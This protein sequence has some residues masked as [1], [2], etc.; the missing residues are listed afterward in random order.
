[1]KEPEHDPFGRGVAARRLAAA[2]LAAGLDPFSDGALFSS[3]KI[4]L[5]APDAPGPGGETGGKRN[6]ELSR[7]GPPPWVHLVDSDIVALAGFPLWLGAQ[8]FRTRLHPSHGALVAA[9]PWLEPGCI[10][11]DLAGPMWSAVEVLVRL[12]GVAP[13]HPIVA[14]G[15]GD[16][17]IAVAAMKL[18]AADVLD[19]PVRWAALAQAVGHALDTGPNR[20][21]SQ[22]ESTAAVAR[23]STLTKRQRDVLRGVVA[24]KLN[25]TIAYELGLS[26][27]TVEGHRAAI[28]VR[29]GARNSSDLIRIGIA[30]G[31]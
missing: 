1:M 16:I 13:N 7:G 2:D 29:T 9:G 6:L 18:G 11:L 25:K 17:A 4:S 27:R 22:P 3:G 28:M 10:I 15:C 19:H 20:S 23:V 31:L 12:R 8:G 24:G 30:A 26:V 21:V 5:I 14:C